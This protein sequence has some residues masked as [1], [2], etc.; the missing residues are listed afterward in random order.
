MSLYLIRVCSGG[1]GRNERRRLLRLRVGTK[2]NS[3]ALPSG[4]ELNFVQYQEASYFCWGDYSRCKYIRTRY[5]RGYDAHICDSGD[6]I[7]RA[8]F[9]TCTLLAFHV[10]TRGQ[11]SCPLTA[12]A[13]YVIIRKLNRPLLAN[14]GSPLKCNKNMYIVLLKVETKPKVQGICVVEKCK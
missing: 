14:I 2:E 1:C 9:S 6:D 11:A 7:H 8:H 12:S 4:G 13:C 5:A 3:L 10:F